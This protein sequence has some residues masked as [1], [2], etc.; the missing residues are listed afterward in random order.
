MRRESV[1]VSHVGFD[2]SHHQYVG[3]TDFP[4]DEI[5]QALG[6]VHESPPAAREQAAELFRTLA[7]W[8]FSGSKSL[9]ASMVK[10]VA[11]A[12]GIRP[13]LLDNRSLRELASELGCTK[14]NLAHQAVKFSDAWGT[15][16]ARSRSKEG[17]QRMAAARRGGPCRNHGQNHKGQ[18]ATIDTSNNP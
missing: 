13:D 14:Q 1:D 7:T 4:F 18:N 6:F 11:I 12:A 2:E 3:T 17:R 15:K 9:R 16:F 8:C 5:D 10:F